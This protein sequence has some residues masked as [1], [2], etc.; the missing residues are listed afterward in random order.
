MDPYIS[1][2]GMQSFFDLIRPTKKR[3]AVMED[4]SIKIKGFIIARTL[5]S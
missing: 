3:M 2:Q 1:S 4:I 5:P